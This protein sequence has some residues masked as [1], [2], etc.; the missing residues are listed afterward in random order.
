M[1]PCL[2]L[3]RIDH[4]G[5]SIDE[6]YPDGMGV[7]YLRKGDEGKYMLFEVELNGERYVIGR[8][9]EGIPGSWKEIAEITAR[10]LAFYA[11]MGLSTPPD[12][13]W[14]MNEDMG[15]IGHVFNRTAT[16]EDGKNKLSI[17]GLGA[18]YI[19]ISL[20][21][22]T[23][24]YQNQ[25]MQF[26]KFEWGYDQAMV[27]ILEQLFQTWP[28]DDLTIKHASIQGIPD[29]GSLHTPTGFDN[30]GLEYFFRPRTT[31]R[32]Y[33][34]SV[35]N[36]DWSSVATNAMLAGVLATPLVGGAAMYCCKNPGFLTGMMSNLGLK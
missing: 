20:T 18:G 34:F 31:D 24:R 11:G 15:D 8:G 9:S 21:D 27:H 32:V 19:T 26:G 12:W 2:D 36:K 29:A 30:E 28:L 35:Y 14:P 23:I 33:E 16:F 1:H 7:E 13:S 17:R 25:D 10:E 3:D 5:A 4:Y 22:N 6:D